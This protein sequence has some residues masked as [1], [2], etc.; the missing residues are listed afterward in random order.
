[1]TPEKL[2]MMANQ[3]AGFFRAYPEDE[4][5]AGVRHHLTAFWTPAM[6]RTLSDH[7]TAG[8]PAVDALV[9]RALSRASTDHLVDRAANPARAAGALAT[10]AG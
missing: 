10:D 1:M 6:L 9:V 2:T 5:A 8:A 4:A 7:I 3:I